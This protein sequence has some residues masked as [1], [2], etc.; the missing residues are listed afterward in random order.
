MVESAIN[1][2]EVHGL[3]HC[4]DKGIGMQTKALVEAD[5]SLDNNYLL[6]ALFKSAGGGLLI[7]NKHYLRFCQV[8][9]NGGEFN[10][11]H[12]LSPKT[13]QPMDRPR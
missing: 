7:T 6:G 2:L 9:L 4:P 11:V 13:V 8:V 12:L 5:P 3:D 1:A 10:G